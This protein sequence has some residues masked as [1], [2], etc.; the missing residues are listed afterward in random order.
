[1]NPE[2]WQRVGEALSQA[3]ERDPDVRGSFIK[4]TC[5]DDPEL[6]DE[7]TSLLRAL[8]GRS[9]DVLEAPAIDVAEGL[10]GSQ[11][12]E[13]EIGRRLG[14]YEILAFLGSGGMA[15]VYRA[16][17]SR[18]DREVALKVIDEPEPDSAARMRFEREAKSVAALSH[19]NVLAIFD[20][21][22]H[23]GVAYAATELLEGETLRRRIDRGPVPLEE[24]VGYALQIAK[25]LSA[26]HL[27][28]IIHRDLKPENVFVSRDGQVKILDF[29]LSKQFGVTDLPVKPILPSRSE[30]TQPGT[31]MGTVGYMSPEQARGLPAD[32]RSDVFS[33]GAI[34]HELLTGQR[35][36]ARKTPEMTMKAIIDDEPRVPED[37]P[38]IVPALAAIVRR[39]LS[40]NPENR[41][42]EAHDAEV[43]LAEVSAAMQTSR[44]LDQL[45]RQERK[46]W[47]MAGA[48]V[49]LALIL[50][51]TATIGRN[52]SSI[53]GPPNREVR[54]IAV[55]PFESVGPGGHEDVADGI[56][57]DLSNRLA[58]LPEVQVVAYRA[59]SLFRNKSKPLPEIAR[60]LQVGYLLTGQV[61]WVDGPSGEARVEVRP[62]LVEIGKGKAASAKWSRSFEAPTS[63]LFLLRSS[64]ASEAARALGITLSPE[65]VKRLEERPPVKPGAYELYLRAEEINRR[66]GVSDRATHE[67]AL[68]L[69]ERAVALDPTF[70]E[71]WGRIAEQCSQLYDVGVSADAM[72]SRAEFAVENAERLGPDA[73]GV[74]VARSVVAQLIE[75]DPLRALEICKE[76]LR[77]SPS[78]ALLLNQTA[79]LETVLGRFED[80]VTHYRQGRVLDPL[81]GWGLAN[82]LTRLHRYPEAHQAI[83]QVRNL[84]PLNLNLSLIELNTY[85]GEGN[86][87]GAKAVLQAVPESVD[88]SAFVV[89]MANEPIEFDVT[90]A[91]DE[92]QRRLLLGTTP[93]AF[94]DDRGEWALCLAVASSIQGD[95]PKTHA[96]AEE[97]RKNAEEKLR[98]QPDSDRIH[99]NLALALALL[100]RKDEAIREGERS[101]ALLPPVGPDDARGIVPLTNLI[102]IYILTGE[103]EKALDQLERVLKLPQLWSPG[104]LRIDPNFDPLRGNPRF[105]KLVAGK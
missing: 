14:A 76:G 105:Q 2:R 100:G 3:L 36:F 43:A 84:S 85:L 91:L 81:F 26:A 74:F 57:S 37:S 16:W 45:R 87:A 20:Y 50:G 13:L 101:T 103:E 44:S 63:D 60:D 68:V 1:V 6:R 18:L 53:S 61:R 73:P 86:L 88:P 8:E 10:R 78:H 15:A 70:Q 25:G 64:I 5:G 89:E 19:P 90:W 55:L 29:G 82:A 52:R 79:N 77:L 54:R 21:G 28:G 41:Y 92:S 48:G 99:A 59:S 66:T 9:Q 98:A 58:L 71:A 42:P 4:E 7:V 104:W 46:R 11:I 96:Y 51:I 94:G 22:V 40:K 67:Q 33:L 39:C 12:D 97:A 27:K 80:A 83:Q 32:A 93:R 35:A 31:V 69:Y 95:S 62:E 65:V 30:H 34:L 72:R 102:R 75:R 49:G 17:D 23:E 38:A 24:A 47:L 56:A